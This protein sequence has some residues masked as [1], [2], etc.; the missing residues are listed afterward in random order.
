MLK[1]LLC[2]ALAVIFIPLGILV[3]RNSFTLTSPHLFVMS[4]FSGSLMILLGLTGVLGVLAGDKPPPNP[5]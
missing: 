1:K 3:I 2:L 5:R 4:I